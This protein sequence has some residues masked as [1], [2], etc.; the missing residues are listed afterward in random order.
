MC[1]KTNVWNEH[2]SASVE[3]CLIKMDLHLNLECLTIVHRQTEGK[4][5]RTDQNKKNQPFQTSCFQFDCFQQ[6]TSDS[7]GHPQ[8]CVEVILLPIGQARPGAKGEDTSFVQGWWQSPARAKTKVWNQV[9]YTN[10]VASD[11]R[12]QTWVS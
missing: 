7:C 5:E 2:F 4:R 6:D 11:S 10:K 3:M 8:L 12:C 9:S 1:L